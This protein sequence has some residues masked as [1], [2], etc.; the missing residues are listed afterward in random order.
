MGMK[1]SRPSFLHRS[2]NPCNLEKSEFHILLR[3]FGLS[4]C[5]L[6]VH[7]KCSACTFHLQ[8]AIA[9]KQN[10]II[11]AKSAN[12]SIALELLLPDFQFS[13]NGLISPIM[14]YFS[15]GPAFKNWTMVSQLHATL[16]SVSL[17]ISNSR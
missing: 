5:T 13:E 6:G 4:S 2:P 14:L 7:A 1:F 16:A 15:A 11:F 12:S 17:A 3:K 9:P 10:V 8:S